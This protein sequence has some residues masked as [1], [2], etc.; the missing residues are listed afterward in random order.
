MMGG[1]EIQM[2]VNFNVASLVVGLG[3]AVAAAATTAVRPSASDPDPMSGRLAEV[4]PNAVFSRIGL[5]VAVI[6]L[7][8]NLVLLG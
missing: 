7:T 3:P 5:V 2:A 1:S 8:V 4:D 6:V